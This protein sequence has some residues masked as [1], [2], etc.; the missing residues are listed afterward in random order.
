MY[1][2]DKKGEVYNLIEYNREYAIVKH[3]EDNSNRKGE[4][5]DLKTFR[6][7]FTKYLPEE[8]YLEHLNDEAKSAFF[9]I[10]ELLNIPQI[11]YY[12]Q[13]SNSNCA[14]NNLEVLL[15]IKPNNKPTTDV[16]NL[17]I[18]TQK[19]GLYKDDDEA[20]L[21]TL[22][23][24]FITTP[25][26]IID[27]KKTLSAN[28]Y[29]KEYSV[30]DFDFPNQK[31]LR[32]TMKNGEWVRKNDYEF[33]IEIVENLDLLFHNVRNYHTKEYVSYRE[34]G[35][36]LKNIYITCKNKLKNLLDIYYQINDDETITYSGGMLRLNINYETFIKYLKNG[37]IK[38]RQQMGV[39]KN[40]KKVKCGNH[41]DHGTAYVIAPS[42]KNSLYEHNINLKITEDFC[43]EKI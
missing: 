25:H 23:P 1:V 8:N 5:Y 9:K 27:G 6:K 43:N 7:H 10:K 18:K 26:K 30:P 36:S 42:I 12:K 38:I 41:K 37:E 35:D 39:T 19:F 40:H 17:E 32:L 22:N 29:L 14:G 34:V 24:K 15:N 4:I 3:L 16:G 13:R 2:I 28:R 11:N 20:T 33:Q 21:F 31:T